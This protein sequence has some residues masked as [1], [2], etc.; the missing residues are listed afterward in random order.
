MQIV[1]PM[2]GIGRRFRD[3]GYTIPKWRIEVDNKPIIHHVI[4]LFPG[5]SQILYLVTHLDLPFCHDLPGTIQ[6]IPSHTQGPIMSLLY[7]Q[8]AIDDT[9][10]V[11]VN[12]CDFGCKWDWHKFQQFVKTQALDGCI[13]CYRGFHPHSLYSNYY[14]YVKEEQGRVTA[15]QEKQ[16]FTATPQNEWASSGTYYFKSGRLAKTY[17]EKAV[18]QNLHVNGEFYVSLAYRPM[19]EDQ[20]HIAPYEIHHFMQWGTPED[21]QDYRYWTQA[22]AHWRTR[23]H[24]PSLSGTLMIPM[25]GRGSRFAQEGYTV[26]KPAIPVAGQPMVVQAALSLPR[27]SH[28]LFL[29]RDAHRSLVPS[30]QNAFPDAQFQFLDHVTEGQACTCLE[31]L[32]QVDLSQ[33]LLIGACDH[34]LVFDSEHL[35]RFIEDPTIDLI[36]FGATHV[37]QAH[38]TPNAYG[39]IVHDPDSPHR[40]QRISVKQPTHFKDPIVVG[41]FFFKKGEIFAR[42]AQRMISARDRVQNEFYIDQAINHAIALGYRAACF[43]VSSY[44]SWGTPNELKIFEYW[45]RSLSVK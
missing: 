7:A 28:S 30:L 2:A 34:G 43:H 6:V 31:G 10:P 29:L 14:A 3:A 33:P 42:A 38:R 1:I 8:N 25:A 39:W 18:A 45:Q 26:E 19:L 40:I 35:L 37:P 36:V 22:E 17:W 12:Y 11:V 13:P 16:P 20:L 5:A 9:S 23:T 24:P 41:A 32:H 27:M 4:D 44:L 15:I 21:L